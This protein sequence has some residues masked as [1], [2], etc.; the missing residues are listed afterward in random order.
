MDRL[1]NALY[2]LLECLQHLGG[3][4]VDDLG[5]TRHQAAALDLDGR[6]LLLGE[7]AADL[8]FHQLGGALAHQHVVLAAHILD[9]G[10]VEL[11]AGHLDGGAL[12]HAGEGDDGDVAGAAAD[13]HHHVAVRLGNVDAGAD[14]RGHRLLDQ[15]HTAGARLDAGVHHGTLLDLG[16]AGGHT[17]DDAG[18]EQLEAAH[19]LV[20]ELAE[21][22]LGHVVV[23]DHALAQG[24]DGHDVAGGTAQ[25]GLGLGAHLKK[26]A[27]I[28]VNGHHGRLVQYDA[29]ALYVH[30]YGGGAQVDADIFCN[31]THTTAPLSCLSF[32]AGAPVT[33]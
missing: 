33:L 28:L 1:E 26:L 11:V 8:H 15:I 16:D 20:Q 25:H 31:G 23:G 27:G 22:T 14:G 9:D 13:I 7:D 5:Q 6:L 3:A 24:A 21:H 12:H 17:D 30:Q 2:R 32:R 29:L 19:H 4:D 18:L 10:L